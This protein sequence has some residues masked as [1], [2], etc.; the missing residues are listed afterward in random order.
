MVRTSVFGW[1]FPR[2]LPDLWLTCDHLLSTVSTM[3]QPS[4][5]ANSAFHPSGLAIT[6]VETNELGCALLFGCRLK[7]VGAGLAYDL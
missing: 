7:S 3:G 4:R 5:Q 2:S 6:V 1:R